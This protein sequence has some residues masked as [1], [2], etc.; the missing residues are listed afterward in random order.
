MLNVLLLIN[1]LCNIAR[2]LI[3]GILLVGVVLRYAFDVDAP[4]LTWAGFFFV[5]ASLFLSSLV[6]YLSSVKQNE[7]QSD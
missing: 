6:K 2:W 3:Y 5:L 1:G 7:T 4:S